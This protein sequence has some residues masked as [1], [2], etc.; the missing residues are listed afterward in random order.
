MKQKDRAI[1]RMKTQIEA[2]EKSNVS[3]TADEL[4]DMLKV[5]P[6]SPTIDL[7]KMLCAGESIDLAARQVARGLIDGPKFSDWLYKDAPAALFI[8]GG[9]TLNS[10]GRC[11]SVSLI[12]SDLVDDLQDAD[13]AIPIHFFCGFHTMPRDPLRG[14]QG[15]M[16]SLI[17]QLLR[18]FTI[19]LD[20]ITRRLRDQLDALDVHGLATCF[21]KLV[22]RLPV[23]TILFCVIDGIS[24]FERPE[25]AESCRSAVNSLQELLD[26]DGKG[27]VF[28]LL[29]TSSSRSR[30]IG[31]TFPPQCRL[32]LSGQHSMG[33]DDPTERELLMATR[34]PSR[35]RESEIAGLTR[36]RGSPGSVANE[37][38]DMPFESDTAG[39]SEIE[40]YG[41][42]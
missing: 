22:K 25:W 27:A 26:D 42:S 28:K 30:Y 19:E 29:I 40:A 33:R 4:L 38:S 21:R 5:G 11:S 18:L 37:F 7:R 24:V 39:E 1:L 12:S 41:Y 16:R 2:M 35:M 23:V 34:R 20:F 32:T 14:P 10:Y 17:C 31:P 36:A 6:E 13:P 9:M 8:E 15:M 3:L